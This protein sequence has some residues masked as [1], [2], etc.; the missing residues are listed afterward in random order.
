LAVVPDHRERVIVCGTS[1]RKSLPVLQ[2]YLTSL[3]WQLL[4]KQCRVHYC[5]VDDFLPEQADAKDL[6]HAW[7]KERGGEVLR[8][9]PSQLGD[10]TDS[11]PLTHQWTTSAMQRVGRNKNKIIA[12][13]LA[14][15]ADYV[16]LADADLILDRTTLWGL[17]YA[18]KPVAC[19]VYWTHW[20]KASTETRQLHAAP[21]VWLRHPYFL[22]GRGM[23][24]AEFRGKLLDRGLTRVWGQ[25]ACSL[26]S[27]RVLEA[28]ISFEHLQEPALLQGLMAGEDRHFCIRA[29]RSHIDLWADNWP[30]IFHIY[31]LETDVPRI[32]GMVVRLGAPPV[33]R[34]ERGGLV[35]LVLQALEP[36]P[37]QTPSGVQWHPV[38]AQHVRG[39]LGQLPLMPEIEDALYGMER[40]QDVIVPVHCPVTHPMPYFRG[41]RRLIRVTLVD[42]KSL[43]YPPVV[44][45]E[46]YV[47]P[48]SGRWT[49]KTTLTEAQRVAIP[50][51][52]LT[53]TPTVMADGIAAP[54]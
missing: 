3:D 27:R 17:L 39:R 11:H 40:G 28:G 31:H 19:A 18:E 21:Q 35:S 5:F 48:Q 46:L 6:L 54:V 9:L 53:S 8:G 7:V 49:D 52:G 15:K 51:G 41:K 20:Q 34:V 14:L 25:G 24:E 4:P 26:V 36:V 29:E 33:P 1:V 10:F 13:A 38:P 42:M 50:C 22:D 43:C 23:D 16:F 37:N 32:P 2:A 12:R 30:D 45:D 44:E 47:G